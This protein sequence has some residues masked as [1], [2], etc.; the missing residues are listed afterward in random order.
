MLYKYILFF[1]T[2]CYDKGLV[3]FNIQFLYVL[4]FSLSKHLYFVDK[5][6][7]SYLPPVELNLGTNFSWCLFITHK[8]EMRTKHKQTNT[9][10]KL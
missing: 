10:P 2:L 8:P 3:F 7:L 4:T 1:E 6:H 5:V 9:D